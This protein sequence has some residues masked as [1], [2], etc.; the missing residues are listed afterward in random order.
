MARDKPINPP[1][2]AFSWAHNPKPT[3]ADKDNVQRQPKPPMHIEHPRLAP[4][5]MAGVRSSRP[6]TLPHPS[7]THS[8]NPKPTL[9][10]RPALNRE[11]GKPSEVNKEFT[12]IAEKS[13]VKNRQI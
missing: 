2:K 6:P 8:Q 11:I 3:I 12:A 9:A 5:G 10:Q 7:N 13:P 1:S 4:P